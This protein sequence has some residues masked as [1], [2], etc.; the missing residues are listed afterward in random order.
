MSVNMAS[1]PVERMRGG[2]GKRCGGLM[3]PSSLHSKIKIFIKKKNP[4]SYF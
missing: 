4:V 1:P 2:G 3:L